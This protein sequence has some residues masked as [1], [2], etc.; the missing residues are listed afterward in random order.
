MKL[1]PSFILFAALVASA[2]AYNVASS[3]REL[4]KQ[5]SFGAA[6]VAFASTANAIEACPKG[7]KNCIVTTWNP[8]AGTS[9]KDMALTIRAAINGYPKE[10]TCKSYMAAS[11]FAIRKYREN[12]F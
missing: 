10:G 11:H 12:S 7:S 2:N 6:S 5:V 3:R 8:P 1:G 9:Q 4:L